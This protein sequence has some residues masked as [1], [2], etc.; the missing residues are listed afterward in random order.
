MATGNPDLDRLDDLVQAVAE[1]R[2]VKLHEISLA[3][4]SIERL[5]RTLRGLTTCGCGAPRALGDCPNF[6]DR[7]V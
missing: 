1:G 2:T 7:D 3:S 4:Q 6:C 5:T